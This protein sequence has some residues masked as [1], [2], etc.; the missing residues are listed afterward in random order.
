MGPTIKPQK[1][2]PFSIFDC[3]LGA[4]LRYYHDRKA[5]KQQRSEHRKQKLARSDQERR[6]E[7]LLRIALRDHNSVNSFTAADPGIFYRRDRE[8]EDH[9]V[10]KEAVRVSAE[11]INEMWEREQAGRRTQ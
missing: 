5:R 3:S 9:W 2:P 6:T 8:G 11:Q 4:L 10:R 1:T 7:G